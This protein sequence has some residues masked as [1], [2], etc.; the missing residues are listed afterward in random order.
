MTGDLILEKDARSR[1]NLQGHGQPTLGIVLLDCDHYEDN[2]GH[3]EPKDQ[4]GLG[5]L[6]PGFFECPATWPMSTVYAVASGAPPQATIGADVEAT[7]GLIESVA[8]LAPRCDLIIADCG[9][10]YAARAKAQ[11]RLSGTTLISGLDL[12]DL[13]GIM[14]A[15][16]IGLITYSE[17]DVRHLLAEHPLYG[18]IRIVGLID[19]PNW[20]GLD[21]TAFA[22]SGKWTVGG[23]RDELLDVVDR[24]LRHGALR[25]AGVLVLEC[26]CLPQFRVDL[27]R[28]TSLPILDVAAAA[29][30][31]L[32]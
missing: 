2:F 26:T 6:P 10:F 31:A 3:F 12:L 32:G 22:S 27:R 25:D 30:M 19:H 18:R 24:E 15:G 8:L 1:L 23:L 14:T 7:E 17:S 16:P 9:F 29:T 11:A 21:D 28:L 4:R 13:A 20:K 5:C